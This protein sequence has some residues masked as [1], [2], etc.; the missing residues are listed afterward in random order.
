MILHPIQSSNLR[1]VGYDDDQRVLYVQF[2]QGDVYAYYAVPRHLYNELLAAQPHPW[3][4]WGR[5]IRASFVYQRLGR[6]A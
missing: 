5:T 2:N 3:T 6:A 1:K 4:T